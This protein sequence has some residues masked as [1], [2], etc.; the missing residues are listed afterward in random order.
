MHAHLSLTLQPVVAKEAGK[1]AAA[2][3]SPKERP[4]K[5]GAAPK[6]WE[7]AGMV[8]EGEAPATPKEEPVQETKAAEPA[9]PKVEAPAEKPA[10]PLPD[11]PFKE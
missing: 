3:V 8:P 2:A 9:A 4:K 5:A 1:E 10:E 11:N 7:P 6:K